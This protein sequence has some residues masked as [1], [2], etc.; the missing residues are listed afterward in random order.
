[1]LVA[2]SNLTLQHCLYKNLGQLYRN[3]D[4]AMHDDEQARLYYELAAK[5]GQIGA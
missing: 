3:G 4:G 2:W 5:K 1:M